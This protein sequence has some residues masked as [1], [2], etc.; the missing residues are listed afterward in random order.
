MIKDTAIFSVPVFGFFLTLLTICKKNEDRSKSSNMVCRERP[1]HL[2]RLTVS[3]TCTER[4]RYESQ[5]TGQSR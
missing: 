3:E 1:S 4:P 2:S 5:R